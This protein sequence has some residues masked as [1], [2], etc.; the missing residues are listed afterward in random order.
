MK[1]TNAKISIFIFSF[2]NLWILAWVLHQKVAS[3]TLLLE[4]RDTS[5]WL[6]AKILVWLLFPAVFFRENIVV[7]LKHI[8]F[9]REKLK[10]G[11]LCGLVTS[12]V[13]YALS[14]IQ[15]PVYRSAFHPYGAILYTALLTPVIEEILFRG[16]ILTIL[17]EKVKRF[18]IANV[19]TTI[20]FVLVHIVGWYFQ[21]RLKQNVTFQVLAPLSVLSLV[22]G[23]VRYKSGS[24]TAS[25][26][27]H[28]TNNFQSF[29][30]KN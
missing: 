6:I 29:V 30:F 8:G 21:G 16:Y 18:S 17:L 11:L 23:Y 5:Y 2:F 15:N 4:N 22:L 9:K 13:W 14:D 3:N 28:C 10:A 25:I 7:Q 19:L 26:M 20:L 27:I 12:I 1:V 24:L